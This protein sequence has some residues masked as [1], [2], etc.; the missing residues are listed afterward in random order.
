MRSREEAKQVHEQAENEGDAIELAKQSLLL[1][2]FAHLQPKEGEFW[3]LESDGSDVCLQ[4]GAEARQFEQVAQE[5]ANVAV[6]ELPLWR[7]LRP[8]LRSGFFLGARGMALRALHT[9]S[10]GRLALRFVLGGRRVREPVQWQAHLEAWLQSVGISRQQGPHRILQIDGAVYETLQE[11][12]YL[13]Q[14]R[15]PGILLIEPEHFEEDLSDLLH[16]LETAFTRGFWVLLHVPLRTADPRNSV[17]GATYESLIQGL[18][19]LQVSLWSVE[20]GGVGATWPH[21]R[22]SAWWVIAPNEGIQ[23][24]RAQAWSHLRRL[25]ETGF[26]RAKEGLKIKDLCE[27]MLLEGSLDAKGALMRSFPREAGYQLFLDRAIPSDIKAILD[28]WES[29]MDEHA[30]E[31][32]LFQRRPTARYSLRRTFLNYLTQPGHLLLVLRHLQHPI[33][34][35]SACVTRT[36]LL[37]ENRFGQIIDTYIQPAFRGH[38]LGSAMVRCAIEWFQTQGIQQVELNFATHNHAAERFWRRHGFS[39]YLCIATQRIASKVS[40]N[41]GDL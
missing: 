6:R 25:F 35:L 9:L 24:F 33:G 19:E 16:L 10:N 37:Q 2:L 39:P 1:D 21:T 40:N 26:Q 13:G 14:A 17:S 31:T 27:S 5:E 41:R 32:S 38:Q 29:L 20:V 28:L 7:W 12:I 23:A 34:F 11:M 4:A 3:F 22:R 36:P 30:R 15:A 18:E 8:F